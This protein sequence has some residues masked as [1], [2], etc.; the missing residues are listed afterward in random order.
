MTAEEKIK[1]VKTLSEVV[2]NR[3]IADIADG[4]IPENWEG[5]E[6]RQLMTD[7]TNRFPFTG[8]RKTAYQNDVIINNL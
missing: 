5:Y 4:K 3:I 8:T 1:F 6:L 2:A 7:R